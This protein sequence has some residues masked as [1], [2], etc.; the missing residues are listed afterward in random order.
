MPLADRE[1]TSEEVATLCGVTRVTVADWIGR[2]ELTARLT[3]GGHR[4]IPRASLAAFLGRHGYPVPRRVA[5]QRAAVMVLTDGGVRTVAVAGTL[6]GIADFD[7]TR[8]Q[9]GPSALLTIGSAQP[10]AVVTAVPSRGCDARQLVECLRLG[11]G[12]DDR[13]IVAL[14]AYHEEVAA[15]RRYGA[16]VVLPVEGDAELQGQLERALHTRQR[17]ASHPL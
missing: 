12:A 8:L 16:D 17:R 2:S 14:V 3:R 6:E 5:S 13:V 9:G 11:P 10:D 1:F 7:V 15:F 4:R